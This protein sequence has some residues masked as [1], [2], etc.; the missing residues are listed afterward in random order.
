VKH[1]KRPT[2]WEVFWLATLGP[3]WLVSWGLAQG[4]YALHRLT[5]RW[6]RFLLSVYPKD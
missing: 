2:A 5:S 1:F 6:C 4:S 3:F